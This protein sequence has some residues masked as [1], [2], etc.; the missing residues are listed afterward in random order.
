M[1]LMDRE[2][3]RKEAIERNRAKE[4]DFVVTRKWHI[5]ARNAEEAV[6]KTKDTDHNEVDAHIYRRV[7][8][9]PGG[10]IPF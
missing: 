10:Y 5:R 7:G 1:N 8:R 9:G 4:K 2:D 6:R 3:K